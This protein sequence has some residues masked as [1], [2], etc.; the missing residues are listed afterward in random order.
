MASPCFIGGDRKQLPSTGAAQVACAN[1]TVAFRLQGTRGPGEHVAAAE[2]PAACVACLA[3]LFRAA[4]AFL[5]AAPYTGLPEKLRPAW[6]LLGLMPFAAHMG[7]GRCYARKRLG[8]P[9]RTRLKKLQCSKK[10][11]NLRRQKI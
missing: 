3:M 5:M 4:P 11:S 2:A 7:C 10:L 8:P 6:P 1:V 9:Q